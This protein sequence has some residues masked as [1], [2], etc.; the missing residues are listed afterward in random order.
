MGSATPIEDPF[1]QILTKYEQERAKRLRPEGIAQYVDIA[2]SEKFNHYADDPWSPEDDINIPYPIQDET[3]AKVM[4]VGTGF[5]ALLYAVRLIESGLFGAEDMIFVD[6]AWGFGGTWY[7]NRYPG[8]MCDVESSCYMPLLE[9]MGYTPKHRYAYGSELREYAEMV[10]RKWSLRDR[11]AFGSTIS[12]IIWDEN[13][14]QWVTSITRNRRNGETQALKLRS[15]Y[16]ALTAGILNRPKL[17]RLDGLDKFA[18]HIFHTSRWDYNY[19]GGNPESLEEPILEKLKGKRVGLIGTGATAI[20]VVPQLAKWADHLYVFQRTPSAVNVR[21]QRPITPEHWE[22]VAN[23]KGWQRTRRENMAAFLSNGVEAPKK[24]LVDDGWTH[25]P[26]FSGLVGSPRVANLTS[27]NVE[28]YVGDLHALDMPRQE[29]IR[30]RAAAIVKDAATAESLKPWYPGWCKRPCFHDEYLETFNKPNV[31]LVDTAGKGV[32]GLSRN[33][34]IFEGKEYDVDLL[35]LSTGFES[36]TVGSP[37]YR[38]GLKIIGR[39]GLNMDD[40]WSSGVATFH[41]L[42]TRGFP[43]LMLTGFAQ[44]GSTVN[45]VHSMDVLASHAAHIISAATK[46]SEPSKRLVIEPTKRAEEDWS[47]QVASQA[48]GYAALPGCTPSYANAEGARKKTLTVE[49]QF[50]MARG[51]AWGKGIIDFISTLQVWEAE[52]DLSALEIRT[53]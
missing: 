1:K 43:N 22:S 37:A 46:Q 34:V 26:S 33:G 35:I 28:Q 5:G 41:G 14:S 44:A 49:G 6:S 45:V 18:G 53:L 40:K 4:I 2:K 3:H 13:D 48:Y 9:E 15:D 16:V 7:W 31:T 38:A 50:K 27:D 47:I 21:G 36:F 23:G 29:E 12:E 52:N 25:F 42:M 8:L 19:T 30:A 11:A 20:Q 24:N 39:D 51:L 17:P 10:A 32:D